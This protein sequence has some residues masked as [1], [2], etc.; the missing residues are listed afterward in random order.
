[1]MMGDTYYAYKSYQ[2]QARRRRQPGGFLS[3]KRQN[4]IANTV[5]TLA[6]VQKSPGVGKNEEARASR[7]EFSSWKRGGG[8]H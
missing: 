1:M 4:L 7:E 2:V 5:L 6:V 8:D 3:A